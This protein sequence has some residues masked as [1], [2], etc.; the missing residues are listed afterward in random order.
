M[1]GYA[2][3]APLNELPE[4]TREAMSSSTVLSFLLWLCWA[5]CRRA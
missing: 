2:A 4:A 3:A 1:F 5:A